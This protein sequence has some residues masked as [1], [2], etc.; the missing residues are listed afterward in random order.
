MYTHSSSIL[1]PN[2]IDDCAYTSWTNISTCNT[3][4]DSCE[5]QQKRAQVYPL[6]DLW[7]STC[8]NLTRTI[9]HETNKECPSKSEKKLLP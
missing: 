1:I 5:I 8:T 7:K 9:H 6:P 2:S 4:C 3:S